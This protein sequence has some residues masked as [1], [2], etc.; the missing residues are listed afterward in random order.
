MSV[1]AWTSD[2]WLDAFEQQATG[3]LIARARRHARWCLFKYRLDRGHGYDHDIV[4]AALTDIFERRIEWKPAEETLLDK[5]CDVI[6]YRVRDEK[7]SLV[8]RTLHVSIDHPRGD[9]DD[10]QAG[11]EEARPSA[12]GELPPLVDP[13]DPEAQLA[14]E[15]ARERG[16]RLGVELAA[17][18]A[19]DAHVEAIVRCLC[20]GIVKKA[21][22]L[23]ETGMTGADYHN[24]LR[25]FDRLTKKLPAELRALADEEH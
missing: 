7:D 20:A 23:A 13:D 22:V 3:R 19:G 2:A 17:L 16:A 21:D 14:R 8:G 18:A 4:Q 15:Q 24:A 6:R 25:R 10:G 5:L 11:E 9:A 12:V 1:F